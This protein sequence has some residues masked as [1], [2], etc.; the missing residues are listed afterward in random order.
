MPIYT[1]TCGSCSKK[2]EQFVWRADESVQCTD[3]GSRNIERDYSSQRTY[4]RGDIPEHFNESLGMVV[5]SRR[6]F[7]EKLKIT[8]SR[9]DDITPSSPLTSEERGIF[10]KSLFDKRKQPG[11]GDNPSDPLDGAVAEG[12]GDAD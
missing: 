11:W 12:Q 3:C 8:N 7:R 5:K 4:I 9:T 6:D 2:F 10:K 1:Y